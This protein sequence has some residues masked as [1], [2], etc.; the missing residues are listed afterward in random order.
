MRGVDD[1]DGAGSGTRRAKRRATGV[2]ALLTP[3]LLAAPALLAV[4]A[5]PA[6]AQLRRADPAALSGTPAGDGAEGAE[7]AGALGPP[8]L[9]SSLRRGSPD[10]GGQAPPPPLAL[11]P[12]RAD[13]PAEPSGFNPNSVRDLRTRTPVLRPGGVGSSA[14]ALSALLRR[15]AAP[16]RRIGFPT[17]TPVRS[18]TQVSGTALR[19][20]PVVQNPVVG[21]P[22]SQPLPS[23]ILGLVTPGSL[24]LN[25]LRRP[26]ATDDAYAPLGLKVG[27]F[28]LLPA[29]TQ[30]LGY[31][32]NP[33]Q[34]T[35]RAARGS[36]AS[37]SEAELAFRS[38]W[39]AHELAGELRGSYLEYPQN[40]AASRPNAAGVVRLRVD[41]TRDLRL[42][43]EGRFLVDSQRIGSADLQA[44][45]AT[46]RPL[47]LSYGTS[48]GAT[49]SFNRLSVSLRGSV[50]RFTFEDAQLAGGT[51]LN[52]SDRN[53]NQYGLRLRTAYEISPAVSPF[54]DVLADTRV[55]DLAR[56]AS[57][58]RRDSDGVGVMVG[59][60]FALARTV[61][62]EVSA[63]LQH[64]TYRDPS[65]RD[66]NAPLLNAALVWSMSPLT[67]VRLGAIT[68]VTETSIAGSSGAVTE[69]A[70]LELQH[71][72]LRNL[73]ITVGGAYLRNVYQGVPISETGFSATARLDYR[74]TRWLTLRGSYIYQQLD[75]T[76]ASASF[77]GNTFLLG[78]R[79]NP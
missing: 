20:T 17:R 19:L 34:V 71:D 14:Q 5:A 61:T 46:S 26:L 52:Q 47:I 42:D 37:R 74:F 13:A 31:D 29:F 75:S 25:G 43:A 16:L 27:T 4:L 41:A 76:V 36:V 53:Q 10:G 58:L 50:D 35:A 32:T 57:G 12:A 56:D 69:T 24:L 45:T 22:L 9:G 11:P 33:D 21:V 64:R 18:V 78:L 48:L 72:L 66:I 40:E 73:S 39:A 59:A 6:S 54:V 63:G 70:T 79:V 2:P 67:T 55:Y 30:S 44:T 77:H 28:T 68:S 3:A 65:L 51:V 15:R 49:Q 62:G 60:A 8:P 38:D 1:E 23:P 7:A